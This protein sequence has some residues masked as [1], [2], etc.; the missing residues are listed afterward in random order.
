MFFS[1]DNFKD[2]FYRY[3]EYADATAAS[4]VFKDLKSFSVSQWTAMGDSVKPNQVWLFKTSAE[5]YAKLRIISTGA[6]K[7][8]NWPFVECTF[9]WTY[10]PDGSLTFPGK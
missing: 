2:S 8:D 9:E 5:K 3:G 6:E 7:R 4:L 10:Q 1:T